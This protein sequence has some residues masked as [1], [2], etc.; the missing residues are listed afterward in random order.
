MS[1]Y[2]SKFG[3][4]RLEVTVET[5]RIVNKNTGNGGDQYKTWKRSFLGEVILRVHNR[6]EIDGEWYDEPLVKIV[7]DIKTYKN[8]SDIK[9]EQLTVVPVAS[10]LE[11]P[12]VLKAD[13]KVSVVKSVSDIKGTVAGKIDSDSGLRYI[14]K[15]LKGAA[16]VAMWRKLGLI[17]TQKHDDVDNRFYHQDSDEEFPTCKKCINKEY[18]EP[19][20]G[21]VSG[22]AEK[23]KYK[24]AMTGEN[25]DDGAAA[26][27]NWAAEKDHGLLHGMKGHMFLN[28]EKRIKG[29]GTYSDNAYFSVET[30][31]KHTNMSEIRDGDF[32]YHADDC[33]FYS[34]R[35]VLPERGRWNQHLTRV[36][37]AGVAV[38]FK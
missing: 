35:I 25:L 19:P 18:V 23:S 4:D 34:P 37:L 13:K 12:G 36:Y 1:V 15:K 9:Q 24:C 29:S 20:A 5:V 21:P 8:F 17:L 28:G 31:G 3:L 22:D 26:I 6:L 10:G 38:N 2:L 16:K 32:E 33:P 7:L 11:K 27:G 30:G 14:R